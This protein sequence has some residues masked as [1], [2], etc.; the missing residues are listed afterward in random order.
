MNRKILLVEDDTEINEMLSCFLKKEGFDIDSVYDGEL[1]EQRAL[2][3]SYD[4]I[5]LDIMLPGKDGLEVLRSVR[6]SKAT[7]ILMLTA[8]G[9]DVD[10]IIGFEM[11]ADD[12][13][14]KPFNPR[15]LIARIKAILRRVEMD[16]LNSRP[17]RHLLEIDQLSVNLKSQEVLFE[18]KLVDLT[19]TEFNVLKTL[20]Q[21]P[22]EVLTKDT[23]TQK[24][25]GRRLSL[26]DRALDMH[27]SNLR[28]KLS[29]NAIK[30][31][32]GQGYMYQISEA[33]TRTSS[34]L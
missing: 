4:L 23:L 10:R 14:P 15:E 31:I 11:G 9:D 2:S 1:A 32:R 18:D 26:Y 29:S 8:K 19:A 21:H 27:V 6:A 24:A 22:N 13:L 30:T 12:Y 3:H 5:V 17:N 33:S 7:P 20:I 16:Q 25:L 28:R 34:S